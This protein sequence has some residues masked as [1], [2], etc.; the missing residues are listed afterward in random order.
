MTAG[1]AAWAQGS[2]GGGS[3]PTTLMGAEAEAVVEKIASR[4]LSL[5]HQYDAI[6][7][8]KVS[9]EAIPEKY[10]G[11]IL[12]HVKRGTGLTYVSPHR[13]KP[14]IP[15]GEYAKAQGLETAENKLYDQLFRTDENPQVARTITDALPFDLMP[16]KRL[17]ALAEFPALKGIR[18]ESF[19]IHHRQVPVCIT[20]CCHGKGRILALQYFDVEMK[21][22]SSTCLTPGI[23]Y[24][25]T[26]YDYFHALLAR[27]VRWTCRVDP[28]L[29]DG[30]TVTA[31]KTELKDT[32]DERDAAYV[33]EF[34]TPS[35]PP[36]SKPIRRYHSGKNTTTW[37]SL[38]V[39]PKTPTEWLV[40]TC[41]LW[42]DFGQFTLTDI[43]LNAFGGTALFD[44]IEL[45]RSLDSVKVGQ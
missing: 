12:E 21:G 42:K 38:E 43:A 25:P 35:F 41:D 1:R 31:P 18:A 30:I 16:L 33:H 24:N 36:N 11:L 29:A 28:V 4:R 39:S 15:S 8:G 14:D 13:Q 10:R 40:V 9:W 44:R 34:K 3:E 5:G 19:N 20:T 22:R 7:I 26:M 2:G 45:L 32:P 17:A 6:V 37:K 23:A 27:C